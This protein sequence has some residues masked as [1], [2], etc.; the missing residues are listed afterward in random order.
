MLSGNN[1]W[2]WIPLSWSFSYITLLEYPL[3]GWKTTS[4]AIYDPLYLVDSLLVV[5]SEQQSPCYTFQSPLVQ[6]EVL[7]TFCTE[8][9]QQVESSCLLT[10]NELLIVSFTWWWLE[11]PSKQCVLPKGMFNHHDCTA[12]VGRLLPKPCSPGVHPSRC[13]FRKAFCTIATL[14]FFPSSSYPICFWVTFN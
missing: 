7:L 5:T 10:C 8:P 14:P 9:K 3:L 6:P 13:S 2:W 4:D 1:L 11:A 12:A